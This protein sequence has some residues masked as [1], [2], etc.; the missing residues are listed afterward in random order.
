LGPTA[1]GYNAPTAARRGNRRQ[2]WLR[3]PPDVVAVSDD[4]LKKIPDESQ[5]LGVG[6]VRRKMKELAELQRAYT[7]FD[8][9]ASTLPRTWGRNG[10]SIRGFTQCPYQPEDDANYP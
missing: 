3:Q 1:T 7:S 4:F 9:A 8:D 2:R 5:G 6:E 10:C